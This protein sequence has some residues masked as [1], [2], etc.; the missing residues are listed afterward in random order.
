MIDFLATLLVS[1]VASIII[2]GGAMWVY[3][4]VSER[5]YR[6]WRKAWLKEINDEI[7]RLNSDC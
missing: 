1:I 6:A 2:N 3:V 5:K 7:I 4:W